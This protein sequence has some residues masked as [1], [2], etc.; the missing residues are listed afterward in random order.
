M[1]STT[2]INTFQLIKLL[3]LCLPYTE[4]LQLNVIIPS[5]PHHIYH[6]GTYNAP[7]LL[8]TDIRDDRSGINNAD[9]DG[10][11]S[12]ALAVAKFPEVLNAISASVTATSQNV[13]YAQSLTILY[14][15]WLIQL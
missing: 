5:S 11:T 7:H 1:S 12:E 8:V 14:Q 9:A 15:L 10:L 2:P 4:C 3:N 6:N 13:P